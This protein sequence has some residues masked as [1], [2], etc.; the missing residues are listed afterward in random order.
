MTRHTP[1]ELREMAEV[2]ARIGHMTG[3]DTAS[4]LRQAA[5]DAERLDWLAMR[6]VDVREPLVYGSRLSFSGRP[7]IDHEGLDEAP[8]DIRGAIDKAML[9][10]APAAGKGGEA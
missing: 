6:F 1:T 2:H 7:K 8:F 10:A 3:C 4:M 5:D 9:A